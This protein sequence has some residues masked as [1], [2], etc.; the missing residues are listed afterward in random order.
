MK[1]AIASLPEHRREQFAS[2]PQ[3]VLCVVRGF[4]NE[5]DREKATFQGMQTIAEWREKV[6]Y[7]KFF[8]QMHP[9]ARDFHSWWPERIYG[10]D[11]WG[12]MVQG[13]RI[14]EVDAESLGK[15]SDDDLN[16]VQGQKMKAY[17]VY[18]QDLAIKSGVQRYKHTLIVDL[19]GVSLSMLQ[20]RK[21][22]VLQKIFSLG[23]AYY[24]ETMWQI[25]LVNTP[26]VFRA[27]WAIV[28]P[29]L[30]PV[31]VN[32]IQFCGTLKE[33]M[34]KMTAANIPATSLPTW[35]GGTHDGKL[36]FEYIEELVAVKR[37]HASAPA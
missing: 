33:A 21:R 36:T 10:L 12:H 25:Y 37:Q 9:L 18:K 11:G 27:V 19:G 24:P 20:G 23:S 17:S 28:K 32:K 2:L 3:D 1:R 31:T 22:Q 14:A 5:S 13:V 30:H 29:W 35:V 34:K 16:L 8:D 7:Y 15:I 6:D 26:M 4:Q